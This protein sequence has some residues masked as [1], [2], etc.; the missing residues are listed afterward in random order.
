MILFQEAV[1]SHSVC[2]LWTGSLP[3]VLGRE[4]LG[5][6]WLVESGPARMPCASQE[7][8]PRMGLISTC[9]FA[10]PAENSR[11][12]GASPVPPASPA[13]GAEISRL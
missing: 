8:G 12:P 3:S 4:V 7:M 10:S 2:S 9:V 5:R 6:A 11:E 13:W 1:G